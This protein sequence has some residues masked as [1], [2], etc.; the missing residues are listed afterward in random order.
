MSYLEQYHS[1][2]LYILLV[3][4][5][6]TCSIAIYHLKFSPLAKFP[7]PR[8]AAITRFYEAY[9]QL[10]KGGTFTW[11]ID[12]LHKKY[13]PVVRISP[14]EIHIKD[15]E[16]YSTLYAGP[17]KHRNKDPWFSFISYPLSLFSTESHELHRP[18]R[19]VL[20]EFFKKRSVYELEPVM[21]KNLEL[22]C[23]HFSK[24]CSKSKVIELHAAFYSFAVD[25]LSQYAFGDSEGFHYL[26]EPEISDT[27]KLRMTALFGFCRINRHFPM[28]V[29]GARI[30]PTLVSL[31]VPPFAYVSQMERVRYIITQTIRN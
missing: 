21:K 22:L 15:P 19:R 5:L 11:H 27:W 18:R 25:V 10:I 28:L 26:R 3:G 1:C 6:Y 4:V 12:D 8:I 14:W 20:G 31:A 17:G 23:N 13:G 9:F 16:F 2:L 7:G 29:V 30:A 24:A